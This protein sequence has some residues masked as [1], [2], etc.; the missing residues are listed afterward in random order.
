MTR[1]PKQF[2]ILAEELLF[3]KTENGKSSHHAGVGVFQ[4]DG[5]SVQQGSVTTTL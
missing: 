4:E 1:T 3:L 5:M 2:Q